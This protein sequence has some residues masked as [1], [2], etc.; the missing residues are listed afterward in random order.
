MP[1]DYSEPC[2]DQEVR[3]LCP[4]DHDSRPLALLGG[5]FDP[6]HR[7]HVELAR[8]ALQ[9]AEVEE[10]RWIPC[11]NLPH[12]KNPPLAPAVARLDMVQTL[13]SQ[14]CG[15]VCDPLE[16]HRDGP[17][18][19]IDTVRHFHDEQP[20]RPLL[21]LIGSD[22]ISLIG[23]GK[24]AEELWQRA[25]PVAAHRPG[26]PQRLERAHLPFLDDARWEQVIRWQL[27]QISEDISSTRI[28]QMIAAGE[29][30]DQWIPQS[31]QP[32]ILSGGWYSSGSP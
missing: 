2:H 20:D 29:A 27:P 10:V 8:A 4:S 6:I 14:N 17:S 3:Q 22:N 9:L 23:S 12:S 16:F 28:R 19:T 26:A 5:V 7:G 11:L 31:I 24:D 13:C 32:L 18:W 30:V 25:I 1:S 15:F 21:W